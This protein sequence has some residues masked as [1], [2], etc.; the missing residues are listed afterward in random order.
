MKSRVYSYPADKFWH[1]PIR[2]LRQ[3]LSTSIIWKCIVPRAV[4][5]GMFAK[6]DW[7]ENFSN[8]TKLFSV[9]KHKHDY[10]FWP[11]QFYK[12]PK[13]TFCH[14]GA[15]RLCKLWLIFYNFLV[16]LV[17]LERLCFT[18]GIRY[19]LYGHK[20]GKSVAVLHFFIFLW[21]WSG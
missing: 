7:K 17:R 5:L 2:F 18:N 21:G 1:L 16:V 3:Y 11:Y 6:I 13:T 20:G 4:T 9:N 12:T 8:L 10:F 19:V 15:Q 14:S